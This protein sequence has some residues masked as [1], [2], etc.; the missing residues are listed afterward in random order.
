MTEFF[1]DDCA[2]KVDETCEYY[3]G[4]FGNEV[5]DVC[6][7]KVNCQKEKYHVFPS[8]TKKSIV[9]TIEN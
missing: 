1:C 6:G 8:G 2:N 5:C 9:G 4:Y 7:R 3:V